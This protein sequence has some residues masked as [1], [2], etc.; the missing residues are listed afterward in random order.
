MGTARER[1][2]R[3]LSLKTL[4]IVINCRHDG[5][6][7]I[8]NQIWNA[9]AELSAAAKITRG[10]TQRHSCLSTLNYVF[11]DHLKKKNIYFHFSLFSRHLSQL[12]WVNTVSSARLQVTHIMGRQTMEEYGGHGLQRRH[13]WR[14]GSSLSLKKNVHTMFTAKWVVKIL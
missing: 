8:I 5:L 2:L 12:Q 11:V 14:V 10:F 13:L 6:N 9:T 3:W 4:F 1:L 7:A